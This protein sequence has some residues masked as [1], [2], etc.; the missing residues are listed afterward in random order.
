MNSQQRREPTGLAKRAVRRPMVG[1]R[2]PVLALILIGLSVSGCVSEVGYRPNT[3]L[4]TVDDAFFQCRVAAAREVPPNTVITSG[5]AFGIGFGGCAGPYCGPYG[6]PYGGPYYGAEITSYDA[7]ASL[8]QEYFQRCVEAKGYTTT[9]L[10]QCR[11]SQLPPDFDP[12]LGDRV[13]RPGAN[14]CYVRV[15]DHASQIVNPE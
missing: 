15:T 1:S 8:R 13:N 6:G 12:T 10:P 4:K 2:L 11:A 3:T 9:E 14:A 7:N 5:P